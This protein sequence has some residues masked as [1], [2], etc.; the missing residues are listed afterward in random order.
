MALRDSSSRRAVYVPRKKNSE[1]DP[2]ANTNRFNDILDK[3]SP[4]E[5]REVKSRLEPITF[6]CDLL[7]KLPIELVAMLA[8]Y[9]DLVDLVL[10]RRVCQRLFDYL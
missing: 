9:L 10:L 2:T 6:Q 1:S 5:I 3:L 7:D 8:K 4:H